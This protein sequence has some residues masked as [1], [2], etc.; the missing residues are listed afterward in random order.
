MRRKAAAAPAVQVRPGRMPIDIINMSNTVTND[1]AAN[2]VS[3][4]QQ[5]I[6]EQFAPIWNLGADLNFVTTQRQNATVWIMDTSTDVSVLGYHDISDF[7]IPVGFAFAKSS[8]DNQEPW[9][10]T[11]DHE[12]LELIGDPWSGLTVEGQFIGNPAFFAYENCDP[13]EED[14]Y[15]LNGVTLSNFV[16]PSWFLNKTA[17]GYDWLGKLE[18]PFTLSSGGYFSYLQVVGQFIDV[19]NNALLPMSRKG[20]F[21]RWFRRRK[22]ANP[23]FKN[24]DARTLQYSS[25]VKKYNMD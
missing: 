25:V 23:N 7:N 14:F 13:V 15:V 17:V 5:Q 18:A 21:S 4:I 3:A 12:I 6:D 8:I 10:V 1:D 9:S 11:L 16:F 24:K 20:K 22:R 2:V 19:T